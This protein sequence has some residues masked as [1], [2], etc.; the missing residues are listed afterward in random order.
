MEIERLGTPAGGWSR[1]CC[2]EYKEQTVA[3]FQ[4][5]ELSTGCQKLTLVIRVGMWLMAQQNNWKV[6]DNPSPRPIMWSF[7]ASNLFPSFESAAEWI[8]SKVRASLRLHCGSLQQ[9]QT[10]NR[11]QKTENR[12][13]VQ[14]YKTYE[15]MSQL[16]LLADRKQVPAIFDLKSKQSE[17]GC[18]LPPTVIFL[19]MIMAIGFTGRWRT[20]MERGRFQFWSYTVVGDL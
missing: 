5:L 1:K 2:E 15:H 3:C 8:G 12:F 20:T 19:L 13:Q 9:M 18:S 14:K 10:E 7:I 6:R 17:A 4:K 16:G 11:K